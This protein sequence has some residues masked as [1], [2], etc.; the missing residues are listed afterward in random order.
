[1]ANCYGFE[2]GG[3]VGTQILVLACV[4]MPCRVH[5]L[6]CPQRPVGGLGSG[7]RLQGLFGGVGHWV[8]AP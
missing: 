3:L 8:A 5:Q 7:Q 4:N 1:M 6:A 2:V